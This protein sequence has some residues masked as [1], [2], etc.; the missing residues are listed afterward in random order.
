M[1][2]NCSLISSQASWKVEITL[3]HQKKLAASPL[4]FFPVEVADQLR[5]L[6]AVSTGRIGEQG[7]PCVPYIMDDRAGQE[8]K[9]AFGGGQRWGFSQTRCSREDLSEE[10][11][12][13]QLMPCFLLPD[14]KTG[15]EG[16]ER[17]RG[18]GIKKKKTILSSAPAMCQGSHTYFC[19]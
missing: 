1:L 12:G 4:E 15:D 2:P 13:P 9:V 16:G 17:S 5:A 19:S 6:K 7:G 3:S 8:L 14:L 18:Q 11:T 10:G